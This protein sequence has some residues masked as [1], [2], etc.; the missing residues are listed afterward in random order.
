MVGGKRATQQRSMASGNDTRSSGA[1]KAETAR[2]LRDALSARDAGARLA[3]SKETVATFLDSRLEGTR[4]SLRPRTF[5]CYSQI[6]RDHVK[7]MLGRIPLARP[8][9]QQVQ[10]HDAQLLT[11]GRV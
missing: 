7:P 8:Q 2:K 5:A 10:Q 3:P 1:R 4:A 9:P 11:G 6:G